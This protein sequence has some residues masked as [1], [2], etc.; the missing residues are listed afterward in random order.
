MVAKYSISQGDKSIV[1]SKKQNSYTG[2]PSN[3]RPFKVLKL[4]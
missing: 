1:T 4:L 3:S 2:I